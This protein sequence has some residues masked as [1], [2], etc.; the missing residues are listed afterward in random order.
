MMT[1]IKI[2]PEHIKLLAQEI[3]DGKNT[4]AQLYLKRDSNNP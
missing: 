3:E 1:S 4:R 2:E